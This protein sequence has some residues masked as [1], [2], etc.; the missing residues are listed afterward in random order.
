MLIGDPLAPKS[1]NAKRLQNSRFLGFLFQVQFATWG[2][3]RN[4]RGSCFFGKIG[5]RFSRSLPPHCFKNSAARSVLLRRMKNKVMWSRG[6]TEKSGRGRPGVQHAARARAH[7]S[8]NISRGPFGTGLKPSHSNIR[9][10]AGEIPC[11]VA[12]EQ[13]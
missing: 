3:G 8:S 2:D 12:G 7:T 13:T 6:L 1:E 5:G 11:A 9:Y 10:L 4:P